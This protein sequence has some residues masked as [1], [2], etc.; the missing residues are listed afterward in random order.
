MECSILDETIN[1]IN[2]YVFFFLILSSVEKK[3][4]KKNASVKKWYNFQ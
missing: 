3:T 1:E 4:I 2:F